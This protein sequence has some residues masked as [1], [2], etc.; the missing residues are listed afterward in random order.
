MSIDP[1][2]IYTGSGVPLSPSESKIGEVI[3]LLFSRT[4]EGGVSKVMSW[5]NFKNVFYN[6]SPA[7]LVDFQ[8]ELQKTLLHAFENRGDLPDEVFALFVNQTLSLLP[9][10]Y[11]DEG[12]QIEV[13]VKIGDQWELKEYQV[14]RK[15][16]LG[17]QCLFSPMP[18]YGLTSENGG[19]PLLVFM[20]T[21][22]PAGKGFWGTLFSDFTPFASVGKLAMYCGAKELRTWLQQHTGAHAM[23]ISL[24]GGLS[25]HAARTFPD[26]IAKVYAFVPPG[27]YP[28][29]CKR[30]DTTEVNLL[31]QGGDFVSTL[32]FFPEG[33]NVNLY[34]VREST[35]ANPLS[36]HARVFLGGESISV[37][38]E[39]VATENQ[40]LKR[41]AL[42]ALHMVG[43]PI[44]FLLMLPFYLLYCLFKVLAIGLSLLCS[45]STSCCAPRQS[46]AGR[47]ATV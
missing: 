36:A 44:V 2:I 16:A 14:D 34:K 20:G 26:H 33:D 32:G 11:P 24:G 22:Y 40:R 30:F 3:S 9:F 12:F 43:S 41:K 42:T 17:K 27:L 39:A 23:G 18:A 15:F 35:P 19:P 31:F 25:L 45:A 21:T 46:L 6:S 29:E 7:Y 37:T 10:A 8:S 1:I 5:D 28:G 4:I 47:V 13:P 38:K